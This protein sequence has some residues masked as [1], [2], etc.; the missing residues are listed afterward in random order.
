MDALGYCELLLSFDDDVGLSLSIFIILFYPVSTVNFHS[1]A[2]FFLVRVLLYLILLIF[3]L[4]WFL[5]IPF[6]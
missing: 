4:L 5:Q 1:F 6:F 3:F 2:T